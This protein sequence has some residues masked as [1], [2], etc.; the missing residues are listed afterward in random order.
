MC[1]AAYALARLIV[2]PRRTT[3]RTGTRFTDRDRLRPFPYGKALAWAALFGVGST[4]FWAAVARLRSTLGPV[5]GEWAYWIPAIALALLVAIPPLIHLRIA[6]SRSTPSMMWN[7]ASLTLA[8]LLPPVLAFVG[9]L[10]FLFAVFSRLG[11]E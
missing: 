6:S 10:S 5:T 8:L 7:T 9:A 2:K 3:R 1:W 4:C 11:L